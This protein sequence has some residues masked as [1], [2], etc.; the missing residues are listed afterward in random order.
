MVAKVAVTGPDF[1]DLRPTMAVGEGDRVKLG[2]LLFEDK[3][4]PGVRYT[5]PGAGTV[6]AINRGAKRALMSVVIDLDG[7]E[8]E[9]F[10]TNSASS[11][12]QVVEKLVASGLWTALRTRPFSKVPTPGTVPSSI[13][14]T[15]IDTNPLAADPL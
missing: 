14:V 3:K 15:A 13:F 12:E 8:A 7:D 9:D 5:S 2:Q 11:R 6:S 1:L 4:T 10:G